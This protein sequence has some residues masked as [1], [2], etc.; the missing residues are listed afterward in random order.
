ML[1]DITI[2]LK[3]A[4]LLILIFIL[5]VTSVTFF[6]VPVAGREVA[7]TVVP[8][9]LGVITIFVGFYWGN[10]HKQNEPEL[11]TSV[12]DAVAIAAAAKIE[13]ERI[14]AAKIEAEK[15]EE[16]RIKTA[17]VVAETVIEKAKEE[18]K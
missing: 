2:G 6:D 14:A 8:Y 18:P 17:N 16:E 10:S 12:V 7:K 4:L 11:T 15:V 9:L 5:Y 1:K 3:V 13:M